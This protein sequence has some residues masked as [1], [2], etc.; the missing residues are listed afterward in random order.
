MGRKATV[1][2]L[3]NISIVATVA[4]AAFTLVCN[5]AASVNPNNPES[6]FA[7]ALIL[8]AVLLINLVTLIWWLAWRRWL[9]A[10][11]PLIAIICT[12]NVSTSFLHISNASHQQHNLKV[13]T[14]NIHEFRQDIPLKYAARNIASFVEEQGV[15]IICLEEYT[16]DK[17]RFP[18]DS[19]AQ[20][21]RTMPYHTTFRHVAIFSRYPIRESEGYCFHDKNVNAAL[22]ADIDVN[23]KNIRIIA[24]H[25]QTTGLNSIFGY[26]KKYN[27]SRPPC[28]DIYNSLR[29]NAKRRAVQADY[30]HALVTSSPYPVVILGDCNATASS[31]TYRALTEGMVDSF[32]ECGEEIIG[33]T[34]KSI[35]GLLR[36]D[37][38]IHSPS[39]KGIRQYTVDAPYSDHKPLFLEL[40]M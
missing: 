13:A 28:V 9:V 21:F 26:Y 34:Y 3:C 19:I 29:S 17:Q 39:I 2:L 5:R 25:L 1:Y 40:K 32:R 37:Y 20:L 38:I 11:V 8:P 24:V 35:K 23:G 31:Y 33:S 10:L 15:D 7:L 18:T 36:I 22:S 16:Q 4:L 14:Y 30:I 12:H 27:I 6:A